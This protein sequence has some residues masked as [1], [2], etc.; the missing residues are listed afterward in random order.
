MGMIR[1]FGWGV[2]E[3]DLEGIDSGRGKMDLILGQ[4]HAMYGLTTNYT[5][6]RKSYTRIRLSN[7]ADSI[8]RKHWHS[9]DHVVSSVT[10][11]LLCYY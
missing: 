4:Y 1:M 11:L 9:L 8:N 3:V 6:S 2:R 10:E 5:N 7:V